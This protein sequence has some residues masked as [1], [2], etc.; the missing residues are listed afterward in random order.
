MG[1]NL[2]SSGRFP[3]LMPADLA[4]YNNAGTAVFQWDIKKYIH[5]VGN[6]ALHK[7]LELAKMGEYGYSVQ[8]IW[9]KVKNLGAFTPAA[10][11]AAR[12]RSLR[13][14]PTNTKDIPSVMSV[15]LPVNVSFVDQQITFPYGNVTMSFIDPI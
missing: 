15:C 6:K 1:E 8:R 14:A 3:V 12:L 13:P 10:Y 7:C 4:I 2:H 5:P 11:V 9:A